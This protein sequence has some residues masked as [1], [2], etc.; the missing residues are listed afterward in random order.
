MGVIFRFTFSSKLYFGKL[1]KSYLVTAVTDSSP[2]LLF[3]QR[4]S[5]GHVSNDLRLRRYSGLV[6]SISHQ[7][8]GCYNLHN[9]QS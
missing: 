3:V 1:E 2:I 6:S 4:S 7:S 5:V 8:L 9:T